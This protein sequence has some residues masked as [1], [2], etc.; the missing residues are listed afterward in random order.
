M[1]VHN[2]PCYDDS[3]PHKSVAAAMYFVSTYAA[4]VSTALHGGST[5]DDEH[6]LTAAGP[7]LHVLQQPYVLRFQ[8]LDSEQCRVPGQDEAVVARLGEPGI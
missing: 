7:Y 8:I 4:H 6:Q 5:L 2:M 1:Q 3:L